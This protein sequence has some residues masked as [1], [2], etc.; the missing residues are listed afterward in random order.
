MAVVAAESPAARIGKS[1]RQDSDFVIW[2]LDPSTGC[3]PLHANRER[4]IGVMME[5]MARRSSEHHSRSVRDIAWFGSLEKC[6][7]HP[8]FGDHWP[9]WEG[10]VKKAPVRRVDGNKTAAIPNQPFWLTALT[11]DGSCVPIRT[12]TSST[13]GSVMSHLSWNHYTKDK[14]SDIMWFGSLKKCERHY[15]HEPDAKYNV[16]QEYE[17]SSD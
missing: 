10:N 7:K 17:N 6:M 15:L 2:G 16:Q 4:S 11:R 5:E 13:V 14:S 9:Y 3:S 1:K 12:T 8:L